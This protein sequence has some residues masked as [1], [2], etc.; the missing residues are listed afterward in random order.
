MRYPRGK[1]PGISDENKLDTLP[2]GKADIVRHGHG[3]AILAFGT[4]VTA[5]QQ[6]AD[7]LDATLVNMRFIKPLDEALINELAGSH[8]VLVTIEENTIMGGAGSAVA[9]F[10]HR[11]QLHCQLIQDGLPDIYIEHAEREEQL[12][13][14][15]LDPNGIENFIRKYYTSSIAKS[16]VV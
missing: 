8:E 3:L 6:A 15:Q 4:M 5:A 14:C 1:G 16:A 2:I 10:L 13:E 12:A 9:E 11:E 7:K